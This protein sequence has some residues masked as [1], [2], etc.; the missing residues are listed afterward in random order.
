ME[1][2]TS[3]PAG[4]H[5]DDHKVVEVKKQ[6]TRYQVRQSFDQVDEGCDDQVNRIEIDVRHYCRRCKCKRAE[7]YMMIIG[8]GAFGKSSWTCADKKNCTAIAQLKGDRHE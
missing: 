5:D 3:S 1:K 4:R 2:K 8:K 7:R 6:F